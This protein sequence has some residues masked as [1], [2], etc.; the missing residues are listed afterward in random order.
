LHICHTSS[1]SIR[2]ADTNLLENCSKKV[3]IHKTPGNVQHLQI[4]HLSYLSCLSVELKSYKHHH[5]LV[6]CAC[7]SSSSQFVQS[8]LH[9]H[10][11]NTLSAQCLTRG[12]FLLLEPSQCV[13]SGSNQQHHGRSDQ[14]RRV[15]DQRKPLDHAHDTIDGSAHVIRLEA[16]DKAVEAFGGRADA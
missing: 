1:I 15:A 2:L 11:R 8:F 13:E 5:L 4:L 3:N 16:A 12:E 14:A 7:S 10:L 9:N 6:P